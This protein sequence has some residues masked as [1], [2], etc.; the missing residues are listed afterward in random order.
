M[1]KTNID[2]LSHSWNPI[3]MRCTPISEACEHCWHLRMANRLGA[4]YKIPHD[5]RLAY[6]GN[7]PPLLVHDRLDDSLKRKKPS[8]IG[9]QFMG[10]LF[11]EDVTWTARDLIIQSI[12][13]ADHHTYLLLTKR[14]QNMLE[15]FQSYEDW[16]SKQFPYIWLGVSCENQQRA[17]ERI[18][19]LLQIPAVKRF[20]SIEPILGPVDLRPFQPII[21]DAMKIPDARCGHHGNLLHGKLCP[22]CFPNVIDWVI[23]GGESGPGARPIHPDWV[24]SVRDQCQ[25][26]GVSFFFK[27]WG[28]WLFMGEGINVAESRGRHDGY[29]CLNGDYTKPY[30]SNHLMGRSCYRIGKKQAGRLLDGREWNERP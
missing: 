29:Y 24:R 2:Y 26:A 13:E 25:E 14:P 12:V 17:D 8:I 10:D 6:H 27:Q 28:E 16:E 22:D 18:P 30:L 4:N 7:G 3:A 23:V 9:V 21:N 11:H 5:I 20:V 15:F 1:N 19:I